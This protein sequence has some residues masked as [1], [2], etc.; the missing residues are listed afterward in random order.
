M[1]K[2]IKEMSDGRVWWEEDGFIVV[3]PKDDGRCRV[4]LFCPICDHVMRTL[5]DRGSFES[6]G[7]CYN[8]VIRWVSF[9]EKR[10]Q[11]G[12]R[13]SSREAREEAAKSSSLSIN[14]DF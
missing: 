13:P 4:P 14:I 6:Y 10:W 12:W 5:D 7:C 1:E 8:C 9:D 3:S 2:K 11:D